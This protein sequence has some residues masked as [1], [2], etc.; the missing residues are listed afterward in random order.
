VPICGALLWSAR[1]RWV[2]GSR[3]RFLDT[4]SAG[5]SP[6]NGPAKIF[7]TSGSRK[8]ATIAWVSYTHD[9]NNILLI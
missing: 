4:T 7:H 3:P 6:R 2:T 5:I 9:I 8:A 1:D